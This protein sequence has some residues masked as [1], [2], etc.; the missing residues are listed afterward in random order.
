M[1][2]RGRVLPSCSLQAA[3]PAVVPCARCRGSCTVPSERQRSACGVGFG[4]APDTLN[5]GCGVVRKPG[6]AVSRKLG[7]PLRGLMPSKESGILAT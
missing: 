6:A 4:V 5:T 1:S 2:V 7:S 3:G